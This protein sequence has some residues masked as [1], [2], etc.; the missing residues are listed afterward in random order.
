MRPVNPARARLSI[1]RLTREGRFQVTAYAAHRMLTRGV[2]WREVRTVLL[3]AAECRA[4]ENG[5]WRLGDESL[6][7]VVELRADV[8]VVTV[9]RGDEDEDE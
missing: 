2:A 4:Q 6:T 1:R 7:V 9:Y 5:R 3:S 8:M